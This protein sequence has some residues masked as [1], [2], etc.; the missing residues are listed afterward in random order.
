MLKLSVVTFT[1]L[2]FLPLSFLYAQSFEESFNDCLFKTIKTADKNQTLQQIEDY[3]EKK[4]IQE[5][6]G[7]KKLGAISK[8]IIKERKTAFNPYVITPHKMNYI[9]PVTITNQINN[10]SYKDIPNWSDNFKDIEAKFQISLKVPLT[11]GDILNNGDQLFFGFTLASWWQLYT[12]SISRPFRETNYQP[13]LFYITPID[14]HPFDSN[15]G[16]VFGIEHQSNGRPQLTSRSWNR[17]YMNFLFEKEN[18]ALSF[19]PW[20]RIQEDEKA[21]SLDADGDD[22]PDIADYMGHFELG[23]VYNWRDDYKISMRLRENFSQHHGAIEV[24]FTFPLW[25]KLRGYAQ[26]FNGYGESLIDYNHKQQRI[27]IGFALT[28]LL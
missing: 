11:T 4:I 18:F 6:V 13:E 8:R 22:N 25:G 17:I 20:Y 16:I 5:T 28:D 26:Y 7:T 9:L 3:C 14:W 1:L 15:S 12:E 21:D 2:S 23:L 19:K 27:G 10:D 24:G